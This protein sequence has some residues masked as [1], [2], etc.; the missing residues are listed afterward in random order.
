M[1][2]I[3]LPTARRP[4]AL[5]VAVDVFLERSRDDPG[6]RVTY[7]ET[8]RRLREAVGD[9]PPVTALTWRSTS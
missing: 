4:V 7:T 6:T 5:V 8:L 2:A 1:S 9:W 3:S